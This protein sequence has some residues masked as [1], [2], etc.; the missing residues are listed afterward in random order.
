MTPR[1]TVTGAALAS[2]LSVAALAHSGATGVV[3]DRMG[4]MKEMKEA[5]KS[6]A[7]MMSGTAAYDADAVRR[8]AD[9][10]RRH[11]GAA[12]TGDFPAGSTEAPSEALPAIWQDWDRFAELAET[13]GV[14]AEGLSRAADNGLHGAG[15]MMDSGTMMGS[16]SMMGSG[17]MMGTAG[18]AM[19]MSAEQIGQMPADGAFAM[20]TQVCAAC[21]DRFR[22]DDA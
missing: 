1:K 19:R 15:G 16:G 6:V 22:K 11:S 14:M 10:F 20:T 7:P 18:G 17:M 3:K 2:L 4:A 5:V 12:L 13:L 9:T 21:H 8:A